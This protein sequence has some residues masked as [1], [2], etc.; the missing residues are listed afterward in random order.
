[1]LCPNCQ[2]KLKKV[3][4]QSRYGLKIELNQCQ[5]CGGIWCDDLE[6]HR[7]SLKSAQKIEKVNITKLK[8]WTPIRKKLI[9]PRCKTLLKEFKDPNFP[10]QIKL[11]HCFECG[12][13]WLNRGELIQFKNWQI[14]KK[15]LTKKQLKKE[16]EK[17]LNDISQ[18]LVLENL[19][20]E[21][22][23]KTWQEVGK[24]L[25]Q[26]VYPWK[27]TPTTEI[28]SKEAA[29]IIA[30]IYIILQLLTQIAIR[31]IIK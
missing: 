24:F 10:Q 14:E 13:F 31:L 22:A 19:K 11:E 5:N 2:T 29:K 1:M 12:G 9:C 20:K 21:E 4:A 8:K 3:M 25:N 23:F 30:Y 27:R 17:L 18:L 7:I 15:K 28:K 6:M 26:R 16:D